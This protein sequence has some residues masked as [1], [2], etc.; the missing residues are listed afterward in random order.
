MD[1]I[2][3]FVEDRCELRSDVREKAGDLYGAYTDWCR[4]QRET[5]ISHQSFGRWLGEH[6][7]ER[8]KV[9]GAKG[10]KGIRLATFNLREIRG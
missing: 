1:L 10:W 6:G 3:E 2:A 5:P 7:F 8:G 4:G 9:G